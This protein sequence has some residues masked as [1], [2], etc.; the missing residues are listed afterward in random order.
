M[1]NNS[2]IIKL[3]HQEGCD[4]IRTGIINGDPGIDKKL[5]VKS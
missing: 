3:L 2:R 5:V 4:D 1:Y